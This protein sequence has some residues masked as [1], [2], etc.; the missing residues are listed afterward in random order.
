MLTGVPAHVNDRLSW[1]ALI[2]LNYNILDWGTRRRNVE[3]AANRASIRANDLDAELLILREE[4]EKLHVDLRKLQEG[5]HLSDDL[6]KLERANLQL[7]TNEYRQGKVEYLDYINSLQNL[8]S[9]KRTYYNSL[10]DLKRGILAR[11]YHEGTIHEAL[12]GK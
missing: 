10:Y 2:T 1:N 9:S 3:I 12:Q 8:A 4:V 11:R 7:I 6:L 5:F